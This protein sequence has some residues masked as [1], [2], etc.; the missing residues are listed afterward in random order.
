MI[1]F[2]INLVKQLIFLF[3]DLLRNKPFQNRMKTLVVLQRWSKKNECFTLEWSFY[4][5]S[6]KQSFP[7]LYY[8]IV[9]KVHSFFNAQKN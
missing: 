1:I 3:Q 6:S 4:S 2:K 7:K 8:M 5:R 9:Q